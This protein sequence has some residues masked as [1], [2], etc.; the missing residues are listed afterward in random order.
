MVGRFS[1]KRFTGGVGE[2]THKSRA[3]VFNA[4][5]VRRHLPS[6]YNF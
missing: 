3:R 2:R 6:N 5:R 1:N 4:A